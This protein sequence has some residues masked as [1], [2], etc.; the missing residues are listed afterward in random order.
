M[1]HLKIFFPVNTIFIYFH[2]I[3]NQLSYEN[4]ANHYVYK[5][6][7]SKTFWDCILHFGGLKTSK[8]PG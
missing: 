4:W 8:H 6:F 3:D 7:L 2:K 5:F 1:L